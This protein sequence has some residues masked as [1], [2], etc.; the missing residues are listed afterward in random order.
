MR[1][2]SF[3]WALWLGLAACA[4]GAQA[5]AP[6]RGG[7]CGSGRDASA[8]V[9]PDGLGRDAGVVSSPDPIARG[10]GADAAPGECG[11]RQVAVRYRAPR[12]LVIFDRSCSMRLRLDNPDRYGSG[13]DDERTKWYAARE[14]LFS[15]MAGSGNRV[16]WG[17]MAYPDVNEGCGMPID[18]DV[19]PGPATEAEI[20]AKLLDPF[21]QPWGLCELTQPHKT[22]TQAALEAVI[23][24]DM[25]RDEE[26]PTLALLLTDGAPGCDATPSSMAAVGARLRDSGVPTAVVG[27]QSGAQTEALDALAASSGFAS[28]SGSFFRAE[29][30]AELARALASITAESATCT[31]AL[32]SSIESGRVFVSVGEESLVDGVDYVYDGAARTVRLLGSTCDR[33][34]TGEITRVDVSADCPSATC[35][36]S[37]EICD[38]FD[39]DCDEAVDESCTLY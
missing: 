13:P 3:V 28:P 32:E 10:T 19:T 38:G 35:T 5:T 30:P 7:A 25:G 18:V 20:R 21:I 36:P 6:C 24:L 15:L 37:P 4:D 23:A 29:N 14:A 9:D 33:A 31:F 26:R 1:T 8:L 39:Q 2:R 27:F 17:L 34:S 11:G 16:H 12:V 22:P